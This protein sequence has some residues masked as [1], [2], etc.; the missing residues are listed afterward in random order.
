MT[1]PELMRPDE[2]AKRLGVAQGTIYMW[3]RRGVLPFIR[4]E[5]CIRFDSGE[6]EQWL[7]KRRVARTY[8]KDR[9]GAE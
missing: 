9:R 7:Q 8:A 1:I 5:K 3:C 2:L 4:L 6:I